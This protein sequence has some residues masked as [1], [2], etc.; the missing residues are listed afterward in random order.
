MRTLGVVKKEG[1]ILAIFEGKI[2]QIIR[3]QKTLR[4]DT[5]CTARYSSS[6]NKQKRGRYSRETAER[7]VENLSKPGMNQKIID[8]RT[9]D[10]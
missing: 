3:K 9:R 2:E 5:Y 4:W 10:D 8:G 6:C 1:D 7:G